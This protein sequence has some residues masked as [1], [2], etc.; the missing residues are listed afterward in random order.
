[1]IQ[2][3][4]GTLLLE[5]TSM[6]NI[7]FDAIS[8]LYKKSDSDD[9][10]IE[11]LSL[12]WLFII[13]TGREPVLFAVKKPSISFKSWISASEPPELSPAAVEM[14]YLKPAGLTPSTLLRLD[15]KALSKT[16]EYDSESAD[17]NNPS[18]AGVD[19]CAISFD[20]V[21]IAASL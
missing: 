11:I 15:S 5:I 7:L 6:P 19:L 12:V 21:V 1:M 18:I 16:T 13:N 4:S 2:M 14:L 17:L 8:S 10:I 20:I 9:C 3:S